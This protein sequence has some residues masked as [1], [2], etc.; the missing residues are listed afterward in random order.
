M[1]DLVLSVYLFAVVNGICLGLLVIGLFVAFCVA[2]S[3]TGFGM[4]R[5]LVWAC[6]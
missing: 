5:A 1:I 4:V 3:V 2:G 6:S